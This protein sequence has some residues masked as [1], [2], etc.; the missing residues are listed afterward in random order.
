MPRKRSVLIVDDS[1][2]M[3]TTLTELLNSDE[4]L[5]VVAVAGDPYIA[6][7]KIEKRVPDVI[8]LDLEMPRMDGLTFLKRLMSQ[9]P[10]PVVICSSSA[11]KGSAVAFKAMEAG[12]VDVI[13][14]PKLGVKQFLEDTRETFCD[15]VVAASLANMARKSIWMVDPKLTADV[16]IP[17]TVK[18]LRQASGKP[19]MGRSAGAPGV[20]AIGAST[21]GTEALLVLLRELTTEASGIVIVQHM[22]EGFTA[23]FAD[24]L[25]DFCEV[26]VREAKD[27]DAVEQ[28][29]ALIAPGNWHLLLKRKG[30]GYA[31]EVKGGPRVCRH[32]PSVDVLFRSV[33]QCAGQDAVGVILTGMGDDGAQGMLE[34][35]QAGAYNIAQD[36]NSCV[37]FGMPNEAILLGGVDKIAALNGIAPLLMQLSSRT[38]CAAL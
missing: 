36:R 9:H 19:Q 12:A 17:K 13:G 5:E 22:P 3:R 26:E 24:R 38:P 20:I 33:A 21:G 29:L 1:A 30:K 8:V 27:G 15:V 18:S 31:V 2:T 10:I 23:G 28:G 14:K 34:M 6:A 35:K 37:V 25:N 11:E 16:I 4:R 7:T 32:R